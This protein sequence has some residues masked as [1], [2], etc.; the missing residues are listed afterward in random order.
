M[1]APVLDLAAARDTAW[2]RYTALLDQHNRRI[3]SARLAGL[4][5]PRRPRALVLAELAYDDAERRAL[6]ARP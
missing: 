6:R 3:Q 4:P 1:S 2:Q 5:R